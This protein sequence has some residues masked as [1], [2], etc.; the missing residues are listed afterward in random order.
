MAQALK[1]FLD[2]EKKSPP[3][4]TMKKNSHTSP[5]IIIRKSE[6]RPGMGIMKY[7]V[8]LFIFLIIVLI[9]FLIR[10]QF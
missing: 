10:T 2:E 6:K 5:E 4:Q 8:A 1:K 3:V 9:F 7:L